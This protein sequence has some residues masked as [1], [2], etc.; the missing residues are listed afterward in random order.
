MAAPSVVSAVLDCQ[1]HREGGREGHRLGTPR[2]PWMWGLEDGKGGC[3]ISNERLREM[4]E[5][6]TPGPWRW[7]GYVK[8]PIH[9]ATA[10]RGIATVMGF[11]R[12]GMNDA[13][14]IFFDRQPSDLETF[15]ISGQYRK[16]CEIAIREV[17]YRDNI[18]DID[19]PDARWI[20]AVSPDVVLGLLDR[21]AELEKAS[22]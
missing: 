22:A 4:A 1:G 9:L 13:Q 6:A 8:G 14:P 21:I 2:E 7:S 3:V 16:A 5:A 10:G 19:N 12:R 15:Y 20:A 17:P 11:A 18:V